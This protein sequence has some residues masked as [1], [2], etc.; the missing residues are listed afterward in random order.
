MRGFML[1]SMSLDAARALSIALSFLITIGIAESLQAQTALGT[2]IRFTPTKLKVNGQPINGTFDMRFK[3]FDAPS[4]GTQIGSTVIKT[5]IS[6]VGGAVA[7]QALNFGEDAFDG[8]ARWIEVSVRQG[9]QAFTIIGAREK[10][11]PVPFALALPG[12]YTQQNETSPNI[13]GGVAG[14]IVADG[15][16]G[17]TINGGGKLDFDRINSVIGDF[18]TVCGGL[19]NTSGPECTIGGGIANEAGGSRSTIGGG[20]VNSTASFASTIGGGQA[21]NALAN[22][23][24]VAGG[25][26]NTAS[27]DSATVGGGLNNTTSGVHATV[28]G[29]LG[30]SANGVRATIGGGLSNLASG[31]TSVAGGGVDNQASGESSTVAGGDRNNASGTFS[32]ISGGIL[33]TASGGASTVAGGTSNTASGEVSTVC[34]GQSNLAAGTFSFAAG[35]RAKADANGSFVWGDSTNADIFSGGTN[36]FNVRASGGTAFYSNSAATT[37]VLLAPGGGSWSGFSDRAG[38]SNIEPVNPRIAL[39]KVVELPIST[40][41]YNAQDESIRHIGPMAQDFHAAFG[42]GESDRHIT[43][44]D[45]DGVAL[46]A[47]Q[48]LHQIVLESNA[49][50]SAQQRQI[51]DLTTRLANLEEKLAV[52]GEQ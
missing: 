13:I 14:N 36:T 3:L 35:R 50:I 9:N 23:S 31:E 34:G 12:L 5:G 43:T 21:N 19:Q 39:Q 15:V 20:G 47:I 18:G 51:S 24:T 30:N 22:N 26:N 41:N 42:M 28:S 45:A 2:A 48:G 1:I 32:T 40:W 27:A 33:N 49:V 4:A 7:T 25:Q 11:R 38:K 8:D 46:A 52:H 37:G 17:A 16:V 6:V 29:G 10:L 44:I